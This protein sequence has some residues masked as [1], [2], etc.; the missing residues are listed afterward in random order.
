[1]TLA[2]MPEGA[3]KVAE[4]LGINR[5]IITLGYAKYRRQL[6]GNFIT[7]EDMYDL[8]LA[9][10]DIEVSKDDIAELIEADISSF[11]ARN[12]ETVKFMRGLKER[13]YKIGILTNMPTDFVPRFKK[14]F[15]DFIELAD[16]MVVSGEEKMFK[17]QRRIYRLM[18]ER[19]QVAPNEIC[20]FDDVEANCESARSCGW[21][22]IRFSNVDQIAQEFEDL[23]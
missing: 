5:E 3:L 15:S 19:L 13:G 11:H 20:F 7:F 1:M 17:P 22:A 9:D 12:E 10:N 4:R 18:T 23:V 16:A 6:D 21:K 2:T 14:Y 8:I